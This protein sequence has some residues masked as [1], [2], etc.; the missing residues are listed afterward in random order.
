MWWWVLLLALNNVVGQYFN[1]YDETLMLCDSVWGSNSIP[2]SPFKSL[3][4]VSVTPATT[5]GALTLAVFRFE[6]RAHFLGN[7]EQV[8]QKGDL[9]KEEV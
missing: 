9:T 8:W 2:F 1:R 5:Q 7:S 3:I 6:D 4:N